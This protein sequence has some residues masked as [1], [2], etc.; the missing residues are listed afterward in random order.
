[1]SD[2]GGPFVW[3]DAWGSK[4]VFVG[5]AE[6]NV[7]GGDTK[8]DELEEPT[9][10]VGVSSVINKACLTAFRIG[11]EG[12]KDAGVLSVSHS[13]GEGES[14]G[15]GRVRGKNNGSCELLNG[16]GVR[17]GEGLNKMGSDFPFLHVEGWTVARAKDGADRDN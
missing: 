4:D 8:I 2:N 1:M 15:Q 5:K 14:F 10:N 11:A 13:L 3:V 16:K 7:G 12:A 9:F 17:V 6:E